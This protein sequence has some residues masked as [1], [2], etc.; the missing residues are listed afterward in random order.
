MSE[1]FL[2]DRGIVEVE[3]VDARALL[4][5]L[6]TSD[7]AG[8]T[9]GE[10][11]YAALLS[12]QGKIVVDFIVVDAPEANGADRFLLDCPGPL[13]AELAKK[14]TLYRLR[15]AVRIADL[16]ASLGVVAHWPE[17][18][19]GAALAYRD[20]RH[21]DLGF[22]AVVERA[23]ATADPAARRLYD[24]HRIDLGIPDGGRDFAYGDAF[25]H[26]ANLDRLGGV[27]FGKGCY[28]GQEVVSRVHHRGTARKRIAPVSFVGGAPAMGADVTVGE[29]SI[30]TMGSSTQGRGL[31]MV[32]TD[33]AAEAAALGAPAMA[34]G[35]HLVI[36]LP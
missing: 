26:D 22:R 9:P 19:S 14:L 17:R 31:A 33:R 35:I 4:Q 29:I 18:P 25:P 34:D 27:D 23:A 3:G 12:P 11:R 8:L 15:A 28:V 21:S 30:G 13:A 5:R 20:P 1:A 10:A 24:H 2:E 6:V 32:R 36:A 7:V 16:G